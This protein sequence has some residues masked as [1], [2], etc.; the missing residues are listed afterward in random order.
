[1]LTE[2][3]AT[4]TVGVAQQALTTS[5]PVP[6]FGVCRLQHPRLFKRNFPDFP[7]ITRHLGQNAEAAWVP[8]A[9]RPG[10]GAARV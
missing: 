2:F 6:S 9:P 4:I 3:P 10:V 1:M 8:G 7:K 5:H